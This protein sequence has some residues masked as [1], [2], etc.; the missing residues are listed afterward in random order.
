MLLLSES[1]HSLCRMAADN[2]SENCAGN[3]HF[4]PQS[5]N[6]EVRWYAKHMGSCFTCPETAMHME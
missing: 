1:Q 3:T 6:F 4:F 5:H 2:H